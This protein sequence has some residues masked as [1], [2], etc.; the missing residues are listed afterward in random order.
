MAASAVLLCISQL[1]ICHA[2]T[3][4]HEP[5]TPF[6]QVAH[7]GKLSSTQRNNTL[8]RRENTDNALTPN[9]LHPSKTNPPYPRHKISFPCAPPHHE[10]GCLTSTLLYRCPLYFQPRYALRKTIH[11]K[12]GLH[13][14]SDGRLRPLSLGPHDMIDKAVVP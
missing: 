4:T 3:P 6:E 5:V 11:G 10:V 2:G 12:E 1:R 13:A 14:A 7:R 8:T 9:D